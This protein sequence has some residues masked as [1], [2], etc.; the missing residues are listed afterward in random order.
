VLAAGGDVVFKEQYTG[1][2]IEQLRAI[3]DR[4]RSHAGLRERRA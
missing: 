2:A 3:E 4:L 1:Q